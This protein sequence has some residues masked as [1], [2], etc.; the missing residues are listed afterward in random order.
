MKKIIVC[1]LL[2]LSFV[3]INF[4]IAEEPV[5]QKTE[6]PTSEPT[7]PED[8]TLWEK[9]KDFGGKVLD[10][11]VEVAGK[12]KK[13]YSEIPL[14]R[15]EKDFALTGSYSYFD[16]WTFGK[17]GIAGS[18]QSSESAYDLI[19]QHGSLGYGFTLVDLGKFSE[20]RFQA[21]KRSYNNRNTFNWY[22]GLY[23]DKFD[24]VFGDKIMNTITSG[25]YPNAELLRI[26]TIGVTFGIS[27]RW[28]FASGFVVGIDWAEI[29]WPI[30]VLEKKAAMLES[31]AS[32][33]DKQTVRDG[34]DILSRVP[35]FAIGKISLGYSF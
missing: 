24:L 1:A 19:Y 26:E 27:N 32:E 35:A 33:S 12:I 9:T 15:N 2:H 20:D 6:P 4:A 17:T 28:Q 3:S 11:G 10:K 21:L 13:N 14:R 8:K 34:M 16:F 29:N 5:P 23:Y 22:Y 7:N 25:A 30:Y 18:W 31:N